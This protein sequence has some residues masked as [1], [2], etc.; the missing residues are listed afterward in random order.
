MRSDSTHYEARCLQCAVTF[1]IETKKCVHCG[2]PTVAMG[3][4]GGI[5]HVA[6]PIF[7]FESK[8]EDGENTSAFPTFGEP[9]SYSEDRSSSQPDP[10]EEHSADAATPS[11][12]RS[13]LGS[14][15]SLIWVAMLIAFSIAN[16]VCSGAE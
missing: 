6:T 5:S 12:G 13:I 10:F 7:D 4:V 2:A 1:P 11:A 16:Q 9:G 15:G 3:D 8:F 14:M